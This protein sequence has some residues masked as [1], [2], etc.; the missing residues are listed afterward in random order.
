ML[1]LNSWC[2]PSR[3]V[4]A[5]SM[6]GATLFS[7]LLGCSGDPADDGAPG[8][9]GRASEG[10]AELDQTS[11]PPWPAPTGV[12][13]RVAEADLDLGPM[14]M[15]DHYHPQ[16]QIIIGGEQVPVPANIGVDPAT[17]AM[18][19]VHTHETDGTIHVEAGTAG[20]VFTLG[21]LFT[22]WG[23][24]LTTTQIGGVKATPG[25]EVTVTSNGVTVPGAPE[26]LRLEAEQEI[27]VRLP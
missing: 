24:K 22:E 7:L 13:A 9:A 18:S 5:T 26:A 1:H 6:L 12:P 27:V 2:R 10:T 23:V 3:R 4:A 14:G 19:A 20:E 25:E 11:M 8:Q 15:A 21:Q 17:G 16:L